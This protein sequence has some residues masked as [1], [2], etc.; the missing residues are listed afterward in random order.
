MRREGLAL[1]WPGHVGNH[2]VT[3]S[4]T[5]AIRVEELVIISY[6][7]SRRTYESKTVRLDV[8][9]SGDVESRVPARPGIEGGVDRCGPTQYGSGIR[10]APVQ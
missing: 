1:P 7:D 2:S 6:G 9:E 8:T 10:E 3:T 5:R 4:T